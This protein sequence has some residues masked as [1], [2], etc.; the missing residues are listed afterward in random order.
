LGYVV[1]LNSSASSCPRFFQFSN[2]SKF[3]VLHH[4]QWD[5]EDWGRAT[6]WQSTAIPKMRRIRRMVP[7]P[8]VRFLKPRRDFV[9]PFVL[10]ES[11]RRA[12]NDRTM[13]RAS[14][15]GPR[16]V[17]SGPKAGRLEF[18]D[19]GIDPKPVEYL[20][21]GIRFSPLRASHLQL[22]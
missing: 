8:R 11:S 14:G 20:F 18:I 19:I 10:H 2:R 13:A 17:P 6:V 4:R 12:G 22:S 7:R 9:P 5:L 15:P 3:P 16:L 1:G 21:R